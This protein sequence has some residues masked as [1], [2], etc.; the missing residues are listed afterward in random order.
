MKTKNL[1]HLTIR[2][3]LRLGFDGKGLGKVLVGVCRLLAGIGSLAHG[4]ALTMRWL[5]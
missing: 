5:T 4:Y 1:T 2:F 3:Q